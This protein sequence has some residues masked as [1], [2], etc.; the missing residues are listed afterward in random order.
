MVFS[1]MK[2]KE[3]EGQQELEESGKES[4]MNQLRTSVDCLGFG[5]TEEIG[6]VF[7][8]IRIAYMEAWGCD[9]Q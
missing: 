9:W 8:I 6:K 2:S 3:E 7:Y 1:F 4:L 5:C